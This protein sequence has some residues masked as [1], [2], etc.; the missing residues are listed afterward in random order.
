[1]HC[2]DDLTENVS[3]TDTANKGKKNPKP[4][5]L[6]IEGVT[7]TRAVVANLAKAVD[8]EIYFA[9]T[10]SN[11]TVRIGTITSKNYRKLIHH[12]QDENI[13][14][15]TYQIKQDRA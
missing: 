14:H 12:I 2:D 7:D 5:S 9:K 4:P 3:E 10:L 11:N 15:H 1:M 13:I 6:Y 8:K